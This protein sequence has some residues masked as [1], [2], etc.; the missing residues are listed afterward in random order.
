M[1]GLPRLPD[2]LQPADPANPYA[3]YTVAQLYRFLSGHTLARD[4]GEQYEYSNLGMALLGHALALRAGTDYET[5]VADRLAR[6][7]G[8]NST[9]IALSREMQARLAVG[10]NEALQPVANGDSLPS[11]AA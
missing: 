8:M 2:N 6:P 10:H 7:L 5:L 4:I 3:D 9:R 1:S 11:A